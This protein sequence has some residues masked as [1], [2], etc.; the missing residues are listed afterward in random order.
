MRDNLNI[1]HKTETLRALMEKH[2][3]IRA[4]SYSHAVRLAGRQLPRAVRVRALRIV[5]ADAMAENPLLHRQI[6]ASEIESAYREVSDWLR[7]IDY[8]EVRRTRRLRWL[9]GTVL[10]LLAIAVLLILVL[11]WRGL[12]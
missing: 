6:E 10:N 1:S 9:A 12:L 2:L 3:G 4:K 11:R 7:S 5:E 8:A